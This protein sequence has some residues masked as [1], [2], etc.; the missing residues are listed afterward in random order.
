MNSDKCLSVILLTSPAS[1]ILDNKCVPFACSF[2]NALIAFHDR[3]GVAEHNVV[4]KVS[5]L[6][7]MHY[8][9]KTNVDI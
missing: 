2:C 6:A 5:K 3:N 4:F 9:Q 7:G 1:A 8:Q